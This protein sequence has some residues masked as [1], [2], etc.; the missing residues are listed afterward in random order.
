MS[1]PFPHIE[2]YGSGMLDGSMEAASGLLGVLRQ[3]RWEACAIPARRWCEKATK[4]FDVGIGSNSAHRQHSAY[5][6]TTL[7]SGQVIGTM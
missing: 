1:G 4:P 3:S 6:R 7:R 5:D 2:P